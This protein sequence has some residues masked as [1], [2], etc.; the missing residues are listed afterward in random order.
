MN[1]RAILNRRWGVILW[2]LTL[3]TAVLS[4]PAPATLSAQANSAALHPVAPGDTW[5]AL[6]YRFESDPAVLQQLNPH[7]NRQR[8]PAIGSSV[9]LPAEAVSRNGRLLRPYQGGLLQTAVIYNQS[10]WQV[11]LSHNL[12]HPYRPLLYRPLFLPGGESPPRELPLGLT[13]LAFSH[14]PA[15]PGQAIGVRV[16]LAADRTLRGE[17]VGAGPLIFGAGGENGRMRVGLIGTGAFF[18]AGEPALLLQVEGQPAWIQPWRFVDDEWIFQQL[19][20]TGTAA[21]IDQESIAQERERLFELWSAVTPQPQWQTSFQLP[22]ESYLTLSAPFGARRSYNGGPYRSYH[23]GVDFSAY[24]GTPVLATTQGTVVLAEFLYVRGGAVIIDHGLGIYSGYYHLSSVL[25]EVGQQV[26]PGQLIGEVGTTGL[27][28]GNH[29]H[30]DLLV[31]GVWVDAAGWLE[32]DM[33]CWILAGLE[34]PC[35]Q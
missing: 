15:L 6:A 13:D 17:L 18:R 26:E 12:P 7:P 10:P 27:S 35:Q 30:W 24:G 28:T 31:G 1:T 2:V 22:I 5:T 11:A 25:A 9:R 23:E 14:A 32:R 21:Q 33:G 8:Q 34:R 29:L 3:A 19:T 16:E 20:L 4:G